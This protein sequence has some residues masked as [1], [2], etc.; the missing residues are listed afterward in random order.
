LG[1]GANLN[2]AFITVILVMVLTHAGAQIVGERNAAQTRAQQLVKPVMAELREETK[3]IQEHNEQLA[4]KL[5]SDSAFSQAFASRSRDALATAIKNFSDRTGTPGYVAVYDKDGRVFYSG[6]APQKYGYLPPHDL[7]DEIQNLVREGRVWLGPGVPTCTGTLAI[8]GMV[9]VKTNGTW[10]GM[11]AVCEPVNTEFLTGIKKKVELMQGTQNI[12][13]LLF[14]MEDSRVTALTPG[15]LSNDGGLVNS[16]NH[17]GPKALLKPGSH[18]VDTEIER[19]GRLWHTFMFANGQ[20]HVIAY[21]LASA[22]MPDIRHAIAMIAG[23]AAISGFVA[24][25]LSLIFTAAIAGKLN[26]SVKFLIARAHDLQQHKSLPPLDGLSQ[27]FQE[28]ALAMEQAVSSPRIS[29]KSLQTQMGKHQEELAE[30]QKLVEEANQKVDAINRQLSIQSKQ[31]S[32]VSKQINYANAQSI[33]LQ[34]KLSSVL[35]ISTEGFLILDAYGNILAANPIFLQ[36]AGASEGEIAGR[37][38]FDLL[39][40]PGEPRDNG[41]FSAFAVHGGRP[42]QL[43]E[44]FFPEGIVYNR[45]YQ[46]KAIEVIAH[47]QPVMTDEHNI[48]G[49]IMVLRDKSL[50]SEA[51]RLRNEMVAVLQEAIRAPLAVAEQKWSR[52]LTNTVQGRDPVMG[53]SLVDLHQTY[54]QLLGVVDSL[55]MMHTGIVPTAPVV[56]EQISVTR[57]IGE[58]LEQVAQQA[59]AHQIIL[60]YKT[61]TGLPATAIDPHIVRDVMIQLLEKMISVTAPG[62]RVRVESAAKGNEIRIAIF[63]SGPALPQSEIEDMFAGFIQGKHSEDTYSQRLSMYLVRNNVERLGGKIWAESDRGTYIYFILPVQ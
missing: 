23:Q 60:D 50:H 30:K 36:W 47:L 58:C 19:G 38:V 43:I 16:L 25:I 4:D 9:P 14:S 21:I 35:Q 2:F 56:R 5:S 10:S 48:H 52:V 22:P 44:Q 12:E 40:K 45:N 42:G 6:D 34:Q 51:A 54:Q 29:V 15:L 24:F 46:D 18:T 26:K 53:N 37:Y 63:S 57:L 1:L 3:A 39:R 27:D 61:V 20:N 17:E 41:D 7:A 55:L 49:Y 11:V 8:I 33:L 59:R 62:G 32:E 28:L 13:L 31:L